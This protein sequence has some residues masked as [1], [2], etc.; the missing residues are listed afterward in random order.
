M[1]V[2]DL[3]LKVPNG[4]LLQTRGSQTSRRALSEKL[5]D[6]EER[7]AGLVAEISELREQNELLEFRVLEL[8][9]SPILRDTPDPAD[10][11]IVSPEPIHLYKVSLS[12]CVFQCARTRFLSVCICMDVGIYNQLI[13]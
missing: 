10:S 9:E 4:F 5:R 7:E 12:G 3:K 13:Q 6:A 11:G 1:H 8:E 2:S